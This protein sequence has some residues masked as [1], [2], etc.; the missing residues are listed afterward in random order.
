MALLAAAA[1]VGLMRPH[2]CSAEVV[3]GTYLRAPPGEVEGSFQRIVLL[4]S[5]VFDTIDASTQA[6]VSSGNLSESEAPWLRATYNS[7]LGFD[8]D[9]DVVRLRPARQRHA[10]SIE[11]YSSWRGGRC[12]MG[13]RGGREGPETDGRRSLA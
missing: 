4:G 11:S 1:C 9:T 8:W 2:A 12:C 13:R 5:F 3:T 7:E 6:L 10:L